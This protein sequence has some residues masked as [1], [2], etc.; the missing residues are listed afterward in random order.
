MSRKKVQVVAHTAV[1]TFFKVSEKE[2]LEGGVKRGLDA[3]KKAWFLLK[4]L[5][6]E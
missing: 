1:N 5:Q 2:A 3:L 4:R 6:L